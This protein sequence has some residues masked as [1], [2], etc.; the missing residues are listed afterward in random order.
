QPVVSI[1]FGHYLP[2]WPR[3]RGLDPPGVE[4]PWGDGAAVAEAGALSRAAAGRPFRDARSATRAS[5]AAPLTEGAP[6]SAIWGRRSPGPRGSFATRGRTVRV[7]SLT[8]GSG[9]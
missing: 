2:S 1:V 9:M 7:S 5:T 4:N 6:G 3:P 8:E